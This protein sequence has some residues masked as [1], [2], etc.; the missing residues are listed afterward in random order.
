MIVE[1][2]LLSH[3]SSSITEQ[4]Y[5]DW[6]YLLVRKKR[7]DVMNPW[8]HIASSWCTTTTYGIIRETLRFY[9]VHLEQFIRFRVRIKISCSSFLFLQFYVHMINSKN[10]M[11]SYIMKNLCASHIIPPWCTHEVRAELCQ[12]NHTFCLYIEKNLCT[13][14]TILHASHIIPYAVLLMN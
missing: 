3:T 6:F 11:T 2:Y 5:V 14:H 10:M 8:T 13:K 4:T 1:T 12:K 7:C 9:P